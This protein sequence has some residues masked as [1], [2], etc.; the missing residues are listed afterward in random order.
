MIRVGNLDSSCSGYQASSFEGVRSR[1]DW[2]QNSKNNG[3]GGPERKRGKVP[4]KKGDKRSLTASANCSYYY[5]KKF[6]RAEAATSELDIGR[7]NLRSRTKETSESRSSRRQTQD[8]GGPVRSRGR[9]YQEYRPYNKDQGCKQ[10]ST[11]QSRQE[12]RRGRSSSQNSSRKGAK[13]QQRQ[14]MVGKSTSRRT[15]SLEVLLDA[16]IC[17]K[18]PALKEKNTSFT[19]TAKQCT[20]VRWENCEILGYDLLG[21]P[22]YSP[23]LAQ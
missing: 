15:A 5:R 4:V 1:S 16:K 14:E 10:Q 13:Q 8:Q 18:R 12:H 7:Y 19:R 2:S 3:S 23:D 22:P 6:R 9:R 17:E 21:H 11:S 20:R